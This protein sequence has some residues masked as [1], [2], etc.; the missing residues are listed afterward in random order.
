MNKFKNG[1]KQMKNYTE[2]KNDDEGNGI[3]TIDTSEVNKIGVYP[4]TW[5]FNEGTRHNENIFVDDSSAET[6]SRLNYWWKCLQIYFV[7]IATILGTGVLGLP[8]KTSYSGV[9]P[10][11]FIYTV[12]FFIQ[13]LLVYFFSFVLLKT[14]YVLR[15]RHIQR[16]YQVG[17]RTG[18][19]GSSV[20]KSCLPNLHNLSR[21]FLPVVL[22]EI[23]QIIINLQFILFLTSYVL[24]GSEAYGQLLNLNYV[25]IIPIFWILFTCL[26]VFAYSH[27]QPII[28]I[29]TLAKGTLLILTVVITFIVGEKVSHSGTI[30]NS[31]KHTDQPW[32]MSTVALGG[33]VNVMPMLFER[34]SPTREETRHFIM[35]IAAGLSTCYLLTVFWCSAVLHI[36]PQTCFSVEIPSNYLPTTS[37]LI[38]SENFTTIPIITTTTFTPTTT[39]QLESEISS[40]K[41]HSFTHVPTMTTTTTT[42]TITTSTES[43]LS[44][45]SKFLKEHQKVEKRR[46][47]RLLN[48]NLTELNS[49]CYSLE[50]SEKDG[51]ISTIPLTKVIQRDFSSFS[52][53]A[54]FIQFFI[55]ISITVSYITIGGAFHHTLKGVIDFIWQYRFRITIDRVRHSKYFTINNLTYMMSFFFFSISLI[56]SLADSKSFIRLLESA[57][58]FLLNIEMGAFVSV[59]IWY[60]TLSKKFADVEIPM[61]PPKSFVYVQFILIFYFNL[62][63]IYDIVQWFS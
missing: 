59:M 44:S 22:R 51:E 20:I 7:T 14:Y 5:T 35:S 56:A 9:Y 52:W 1:N 37:S 18:E 15:E 12:N 54:Y 48:V 23:F 40:L 26:I 38:I 31:W 43:L 13:I 19:N 63:V 62:A 30:K 57:S 55:V 32:L 46:V 53:I 16:E 45:V 17:E 36:V 21:L 34:C 42:T 61:M 8:V 39:D 29:F 27:I 24:A 2:L 4:V 47:K 6:I 33:I 25:Y 41:L 10:F 58:S 60:S 11:V 28:S 50:K 3:S 49:V